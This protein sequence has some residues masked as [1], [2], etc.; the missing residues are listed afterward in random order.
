MCYLYCGPAAWNSLPA[1]LHD[2][3]LSLNTFRPTLKTSSGNFEDDSGQWRSETG[4]GSG[5]P[6]S[7]FAEG[8]H[9]DD[10]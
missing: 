3:S 6:P 7:A 1:A 2:D 10:R 4:G 8:R 5:P 9:I